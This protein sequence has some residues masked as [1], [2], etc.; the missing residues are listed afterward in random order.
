LRPGQ[1]SKSTLPSKKVVSVNITVC[2]EV[3]CQ[4]WGNRWLPEQLHGGCHCAGKRAH[5]LEALCARVVAE[6]RA[7]KQ[8]CG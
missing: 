6:D 7:F 2:V 1:Y 5:D 4:N 3:S 8:P